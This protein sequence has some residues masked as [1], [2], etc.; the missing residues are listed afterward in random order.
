MRH[1][2]TYLATG[3]R[4]CKGTKTK[5]HVETSCERRS[6][7]KSPKMEFPDGKITEGVLTE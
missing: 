7:Q 2:F 5:K 4:S 6:V 3:H 1:H